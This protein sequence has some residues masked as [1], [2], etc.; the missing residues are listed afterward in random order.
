[1]YGETNFDKILEEFIINS[2]TNP[3]YSPVFSPYY[4]ECDFTDATNKSL[5][6]VQEEIP[7][8]ALVF[9]FSENQ[10][11]RVTYFGLP[12]QLIVSTEASQSDLDTA[13]VLMLEQLQRIG[14]PVAN[15]RILSPFSVEIEPRALRSRRAEKLFFSNSQI[16]MRFDRILHL[17]ENL[18]AG[19][20]K[21]VRQALKQIDLDIK[22]ISKDSLF[23][24]ITAGINNL[25]GLH[26]ESAGRLTRSSASW[27]YQSRF[28]EKGAAVIVQG[29]LRNEI[30]TSALFMQNANN[31]FYAVSASS[32][33]IPEISLSHLIVDY[34]A[35]KL[36]DLGISKI[37]LGEQY[38]NMIKPISEKEQR[39]QEFKSYFGGIIQTH[40]VSSFRP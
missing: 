9:S 1:V 22:L 31:A 24:E 29:S 14:V 12:A 18:G 19:Y 8:V 36:P 13:I 35:R 25:K 23:E 30:V 6:I 39:I 7:I 11:K 28:V 10:T 5:V 34:A 32:Q 40:L 16:E 17:S 3:I 38:T 20:S 27:D 21:S 4:Q 15:G 26:Y 33:R 37:W 2:G